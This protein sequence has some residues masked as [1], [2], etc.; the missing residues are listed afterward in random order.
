MAGTMNRPA[1]LRENLLS[2][3]SRKEARSPG[4]KPGKKAKAWRKWAEHYKAVAEGT[5]VETPAT[6]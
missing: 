4:K 2:K 3:I 5:V 1:R 6:T